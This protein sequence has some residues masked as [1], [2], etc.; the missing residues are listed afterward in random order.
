MK[1]R[2]KGHRP[3]KAHS[4]DAAF[5]VRATKRKIC[6][7]FYVKYDTGLS[8]QP[9]TTD[10]FTIGAARSGIY[11]PGLWLSNGTG[12]IDNGY[13]GTVKFVF[14]TK[15]WAFLPWIRKEDGKLKFSWN[16]LYEVGDRIGQ[17]YNATSIESNFVR[18]NFAQTDRGTNGH[19]STG[20]K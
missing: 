8:V 19:G 2:F 18:E 14:F 15:W 5:D 3:K 6:F 16:R 13:T 10:L 11:K 20:T 4:S 9:E 17:I 12:I 7:P 1:I